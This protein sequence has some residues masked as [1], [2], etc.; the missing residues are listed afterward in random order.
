L[1]NFAL[2]PGVGGGGLPG[3][4]FV[5]CTVTTA[6]LVTVPLVLPAVSVYVVVVDGLTDAVPLA[7]TTPTPLSMVTCV[8]LADD[9]L[10]SA[11]WPALMEAGEALNDAVG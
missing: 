7:G 10:S 1:T 5:A 6:D 9:Q 2:V 8:A 3:G 11:D 4:G